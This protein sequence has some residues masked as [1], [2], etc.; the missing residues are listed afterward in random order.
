M[1]DLQLPDDWET[2]S[3]SDIADVIDP[4]PSH[5][6]PTEVRDGV[7]FAGIGDFN[8]RGEIV[9]G[10]VRRVAPTVLTEHG[11]RY[12]INEMSIGFGRVASIGKVIDFRREERETA[13]SP[14][15]A[16]IQPRTIDKRYLVTALNGTSVSRQIQRLLTGSTRS[17]L[18]IALL[19]DLRIPVPRDRKYCEE[20]GAIFSAVDEAIEQTEALIAKTQQIKIGLTH[21]VFTRGVTAN[22]LLRPPREEAPQ[23]YKESSLG[24]IPKEWAAVELGQVVPRAVYGIS[25][26]LGSGPGIPVLRMNNLCDGEAELSQLKFS[27]SPLARTLLLRSGDVLFNRTNSIDHV[28]R[29]GIWRGQLPEASFASYLVRLD[30]D[31]ARLRAEFL[32]AWLNWEA[33]QIRIRRFAT[34]GVHQ[35]NI[36]PTNLRRTTIALPSELA[37]QDLLVEALDATAA[38]LR[39]HSVDLQKLRHVKQGIVHDLLSG[40]VAGFAGSA[41]RRERAANV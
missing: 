31:P 39:A 35:V 3:L 6:A 7:P 21:D 20:I 13:I 2:V 18:G 26:S 24:W 19:R 11:V 9:S 25:V 32:N 12:R 14:T 1:D 16:V 10:S 38:S 22:G 36:N 4:H 40:R 29:T 41:D 5:R 30:P 33:T 28:G 17:S 37:E 27:T 8:A 15:M 34:P 23:L